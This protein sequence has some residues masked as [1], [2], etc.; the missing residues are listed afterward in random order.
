MIRAMLAD[1]DQMPLR[2]EGWVDLYREAEATKSKVDRIMDK[3]EEQSGTK[4]CKALAGLSEHEK[5]KRAIKGS[6]KSPPTTVDRAW[7]LMHYV[8]PVRQLAK[9]R[10]A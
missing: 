9:L 6:R 1:F 8:A 4:L 10:R 3:A 5:M 2:P 7:S